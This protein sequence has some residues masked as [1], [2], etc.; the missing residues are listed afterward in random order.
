MSPKEYNKWHYLV[1]NGTKDCGKT[2]FEIRMHNPD[3]PEFLF[4]LSEYERDKICQWEVEFEDL[5]KGLNENEILELLKKEVLI[6]QIQHACED[7]RSYAKRGLNV[8][9]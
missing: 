6:H 8:R 4:L 3:I 9:H 7:K 1:V 2:K 5:P